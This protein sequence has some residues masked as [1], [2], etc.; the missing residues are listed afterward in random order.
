MTQSPPKNVRRRVVA[1]SSDETEEEIIHMEDDSLSGDAS[2]EGG[3]SLYSHED[4]DENGMALSI[5]ELTFDLGLMEQ[6][7]F[8]FK[9][10]CIPCTNAYW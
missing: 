1:V 6:F 5:G 9:V 7:L 2:G 10:Y 3:S 4:D 8:L